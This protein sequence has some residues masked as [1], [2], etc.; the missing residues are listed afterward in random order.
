MTPS[1]RLTPKQET[2]NALLAGPAQHILLYGGSRSGKTF[3]ECRAIAMRALLASGSRHG[4][5]RFRANAVRASVVNDTWPK[6]LRLCFPGLTAHVSQ[7][8]FARFP[9]GSEV[10]FGGLDEKERVEKVLGM[11]FATLLLNEC[12]Q[13]P[14][15]SREILLSRLAQ[16]VMVD[17]PG[18]PSRPL[19]LKAYYD[20]NPPDKGHWSYRLF[21][22]KVNPETRVPLPNPDDYAHMQIN[23]RDNEANLAA[24]YISKTL[25]GMSA[26]MRRRFEHGEFRDAN[27]NALFPEANL[28]QWRVTDG[29]APD[30]V[31]VV[32]AVD[33]SGSGDVDNADN[34]AIGIV[35]AALGMDGNAYLLEDVTVKAGPATWGKVATSAYE[36]HEADVIVGE[37]NFGGAMVKHVIQ[38][39]RPR[40]PYKEVRASRGK[41]A[42]ADPIAA[43]CETGKVR[44][45][46]Y[47]P[48]LEDELSGFTTQGYVGGSSPNRADAFIWAMSELF[49]GI[50]SEKSETDLS[51]FR[52]S[53]P[54]Y[55]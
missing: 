54:A 26:R 33:P 23:P 17:A 2:A 50:V 32:V 36:R 38:T 41:V 15:A 10:Y 8:G 43:L 9:N 3:L 5:F 21:V 1:F 44:L 30:F 39:A 42:R 16:K 55:G 7:E 34:D 53:A 52:P 20:E 40:T 46:G 11:E 18:V 22:Q 37:V 51:K 47:F 14:Y 29:T 35:V 13:I 25:G 49:P 48:E 28:D 19:V 27:P 31:R 12:S 24:N 4:I 45:V 6:M